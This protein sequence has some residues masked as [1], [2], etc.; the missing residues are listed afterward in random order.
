MNILRVPKML[1]SHLPEG[2]E[3]IVGTFAFLGR[4]PETTSPRP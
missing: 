1:H 4:C 3:A 2:N